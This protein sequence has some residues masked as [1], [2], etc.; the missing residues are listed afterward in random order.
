[1]MKN[2]A[3]QN[4][5]SLVQGYEFFRYWKNL[6]QNGGSNSTPVVV[7]NLRLNRSKKIEINW[8]DL[9]NPNFVVHILGLKH[10]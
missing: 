2:V 5:F 7:F 4:N 9:S 1:M 8:A 10:T 3:S 6:A